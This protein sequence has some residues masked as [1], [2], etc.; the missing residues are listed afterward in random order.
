MIL[1]APGKFYGRSKFGSYNK[2]KSQ[3]PSAAHGWHHLQFDIFIKLW[4]AKIDNQ[5][6]AY[7][8]QRKSWNKKNLF[9]QIMTWLMPY[10]EAMNYL[11]RLCYLKMSSNWFVKQIIH[12]R[13]GDFITLSNKNNFLVLGDT[14]GF[15]TG[16]ATKPLIVSKYIRFPGKCFWIDL[17][18]L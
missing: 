3:A 12:F 1:C 5:F 13:F 7:K 17:T 16:S 14:Y 10:Q 6:T 15:A 8:I 2:E 9:L 11:W 4:K 18:F